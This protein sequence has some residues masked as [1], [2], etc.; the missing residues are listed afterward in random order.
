MSQLQKITFKVFDYIEE[1]DCFVVNNEFKTITHKLGIAEWN[2]VVWIG[3]YFCLDNDYGEH[4]FDN[5]DEQELLLDKAK[6]IGI[7]E[8][9]ELMIINPNRFVNNTD[10]PCHT[11]E[12]RKQFW[13][14][15]LSS[16][17]IS[18]QTLINECRKV[19]QKEN[20]EINLLE[21]EQIINQLSEK[22]ANQ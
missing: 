10:G 11:K 20:A 15:V 14:D 3:R 21:A 5:W 13:H 17:Q 7:E 12:E 4:W 22:Y 19:A 1:I 16:L 9:T 8:E 2:E 18:L 6:Q